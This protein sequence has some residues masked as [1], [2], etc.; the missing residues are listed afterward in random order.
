M[1]ALIE[2]NS[3]NEEN[4]TGIHPDKAINLITKISKLKNIKIKGLMTMAPCTEDPEQARPYFKATKQLFDKIKALSIQNVEMNIL[5]MGMSHSYKIAIE[6]GATQ[7]R[8]GTIIF[9][10]RKTPG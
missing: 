10:E 1:P 7:V 6:E 5:S 2:I 8:L 9:G 4:K 3:G